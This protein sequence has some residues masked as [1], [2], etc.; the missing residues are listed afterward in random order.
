MVDKK[1]R[2]RKRRTSKEGGEPFHTKYRP[3][4]FGE[5]VGQDSAASSLARVLES[6]DR[7]HSFLFTGPSGVGKTTLARIIGNHLEILR[8]NFIEIDAATHSGI[9]AMRK[10][11]ESAETRGLGD[12][13]K[14]VIIDECHSLSKQAWQS[15]LKLVEEPPEH[16]YIVFCTTEAA[17]VPKTIKTRCAHYLLKSVQIKDIEDLVTKVY[18]KEKTSESGLGRSELRAIAASADG[19]VRQSLVY[20]QACMHCKSRREVAEVISSLDASAEEIEIARAV[21]GKATFTKIRKMI[22]KL[23]SDNCEAVRIITMNY[24][25]KAALSDNATEAKI[26][27]CLEVMDE[28]STPFNPSEKKAPLLLAVGRLFL[29]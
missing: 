19:S 12:F 8:H 27:W 15:W 3:K 21:V 9:D 20:L 11:K 23:E 29:M 7:P 22:A 1:L 14:I 28:F 16:L 6:K 13:K 26:G 24:A 25:C 18:K 5:V 17:K 4:T 10:I 2:R